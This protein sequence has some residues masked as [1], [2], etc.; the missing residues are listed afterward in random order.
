MVGRKVASHEGF[1]YSAGMK[2]H[3]DKNWTAD[4]LNHFLWNPKKWVPGT[5]MAFA[6]FPKDQDRANVIAYLNSMSD[7]PAKLGK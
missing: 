3:G 6:G 5:I 1:N 4:E 7:A 2:S